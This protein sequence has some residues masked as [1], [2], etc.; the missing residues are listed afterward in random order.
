ML[1]AKQFTFSFHNKTH[2]IT[3]YQK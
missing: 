2:A 3:N 1:Q